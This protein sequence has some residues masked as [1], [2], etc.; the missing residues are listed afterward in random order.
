MTSYGQIKL[1]NV[2][3]QAE[4]E[5]EYRRRKLAE[6]KESEEKR[7]YEAEIARQQEKY[8]TFRSYVSSVFPNYKW[9]GHDIQ[10][11]DVLQRVADGEIKRLMVFE[12]PRH[13]KT[14]LASRLFPSY[15]QWRHRQRSIGLT[16]YSDNLSFGISRKA[17]DYYRETGRVVKEEASSPREWHTQDDGIMWAVGR[18]GSITG[19]GAHLLLIDDPIKG[20][21]E[22]ESDKIRRDL[23]DWYD[24]DFITRLEPDG[25]VILI[26]TRWHENDLAGELLARE[27]DEP[28]HWHIVNFE[29]IKE[30]DPIEFPSTCTVEPDHRQPGEAL[31]PERFTIERLRK[32][33]RQAPRVFRSLY[34]QRPTAAEGNLWK[35]EWFP[36][37]NIFDEP[38][39]GLIDIGS[40]WDTAYTDEE[41][42]AASA[43][44]TG[45]WDPKSK[46]ICL[47]NCDFEWYEFPELIKWMR[48]TQ[49]PH[50]IEKK[51][52]GKSAK[53]V[54]S[55]L[56]I[57]AK[58]VEVDG[59]D[60]VTR[61]TLVT[62]WAENGQIR[63]SR[64]I[65]EKLLDDERQGILK[66][67][68]SKYKDLNDAFVQMINRLSKHEKRST[69]DDLISFT[70]HER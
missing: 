30:K 2:Q 57:K 16:T 63:I 61:T 60:K 40:D 3:I 46:T 1:N 23:L 35:R 58:E 70:G 7:K 62:V 43:F 34:Q 64:H 31:C 20:R 66:F 10:L 13:G 24:S 41:E 45:G 21:K 54:L 37:A 42:N 69:S 55:K 27:E 29:A 49:A 32:M 18:G 36:E 8:G 33:Q 11:A 51:A 39:K 28:E 44:C 53:Q 38:P 50:Y 59:G 17:R 4:A 52:T 56:K 25:A 67:P 65:Y 5:L 48:R 14:E 6:E 26:Q 68:N 22:A 47:L 19:K 12:P 9:Y 15:Y